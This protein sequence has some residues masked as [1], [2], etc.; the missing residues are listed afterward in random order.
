MNAGETFQALRS[1]GSG[2]EHDRDEIVT[3]AIDRHRG[4]AEIGV[5]E[6]RDLFR[7]DSKLSRAILIDLDDYLG[8]ASGS[9]S[10]AVGD[11]HHSAV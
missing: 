11:P 6:L 7:G 4:T 8:D 3:L 5:E 10:F 1:V 2:T 9:A